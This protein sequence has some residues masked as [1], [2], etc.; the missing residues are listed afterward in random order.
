MKRDSQLAHLNPR[1]KQQAASTLRLAGNLGFWLQLVL[2]VI[3]AV[4]LLLSIA[5][6][7]TN[8]LQGKNLNSAAVGFSIF[9]ATGGVM[10]LVVS[11]IIFFR[12]KKIARLIQTPEVRDRPSKKY[13]LRMIKIGLIPNLIGML[14]SIMG[15]EAYVGILLGKLSNITPGV[16]ANTG[17]VNLP[18]ANEIL[19]VLANTH[20]ILCHFVGIIISLWLLDRLNAHNKANYPE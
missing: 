10:T 18:T 16:I 5:G 14:L 7:S 13:T 12:Y 15:A 3:A 1:R 9:C 20:T 17:N 2:G 8:P 11:I 19:L 6:L 4:L